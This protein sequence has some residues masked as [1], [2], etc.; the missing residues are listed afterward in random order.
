MNK[1][2]LTTIKKVWYLFTMNVCLKLFKM[3]F[4]YLGVTCFMVIINH[5]GV[6]DTI[7]W[8]LKNCYCNQYR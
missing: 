3:R 4:S 7:S 2:I 1:Y 8:W 5:T 6:I